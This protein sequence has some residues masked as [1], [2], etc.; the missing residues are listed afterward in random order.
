ML[1][2]DDFRYRVKRGRGP[3]MW[4]SCEELFDVTEVRPYWQKY[5]KHRMVSENPIPL[6]RAM[7][8]SPTKIL[9]L[10]RIKNDHYFLVEFAGLDAPVLIPC[11]TLKNISPEL[12]I[13]YFEL[14]MTKQTKD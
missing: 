6:S 2:D 1:G 11:Q 13:D 8:Q 14:K 4:V 12:V 9:D 7:I 3:Q 5:S 10:K